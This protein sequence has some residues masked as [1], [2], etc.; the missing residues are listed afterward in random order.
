MR[1]D[2]STKEQAEKHVLQEIDEAKARFAKNMFDSTR[3]V[4]LEIGRALEKIR[5]QKSSICQEIK[6]FLR[7]EISRHMISER[8]IEKYSL[9][10]WKSQEFAEFGRKGARQRKK[11]AEEISA[12]ANAQQEVAA[13]EEDEQATASEQEKRQMDP[14]LLAVDAGATQ[15]LIAGDRQEQH[16]QPGQDLQSG[17]N[18]ASTAIPIIPKRI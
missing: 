17:R 16:E 9:Q 8:I 2:S 4:V 11:L 12:S 7:D 18:R 13:T 1:H 3:N 6:T 10:E 5:P 14:I 15:Q